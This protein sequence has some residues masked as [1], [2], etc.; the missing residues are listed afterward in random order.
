MP[1]ERLTEGEIEQL[2]KACVLATLSSPIPRSRSQRMGPPMTSEDRKNKNM[3][4]KLQFFSRPNRDNLMQQLYHEDLT[5]LYDGD[6]RD[7]SGDHFFRSAMDDDSTSD[8]LQDSQSPYWDFKHLEQLL[9]KDTSP[10]SLCQD[11]TIKKI[12]RKYFATQ[13]MDTILKLRNSSIKHE[14]DLLGN[15]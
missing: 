6:D 13:F 5:S 7:Y 10:L 3:A 14:C 8:A 12:C 9:I 1:Y 2:G 4:E 11:V 15:H